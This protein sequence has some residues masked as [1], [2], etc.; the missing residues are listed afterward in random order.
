MDIM[1]VLPPKA[2][3]IY[4]FDDFDVA[5]EL[6]VFTGTLDSWEYPGRESWVNRWL[7]HRWK[8]IACILP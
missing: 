1:D 4:G 7:I 6:V 2:M 3:I 5:Q 8:N